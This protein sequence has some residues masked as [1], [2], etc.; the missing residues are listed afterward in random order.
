MNVRIGRP[1]MR[2]ARGL[3]PIKYMLLPN[4]EKRSIRTPIDG[5]D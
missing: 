2:A 4:L 3:L 5:D 1:L